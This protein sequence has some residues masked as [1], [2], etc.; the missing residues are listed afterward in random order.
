MKTIFYQTEVFEKWRFP[1]TIDRV[2]KV[3][4]SLPTKDVEGL[5]SVGLVQSDRAT[6]HR[7]GVYYSQPKPVIKL[8]AYP[9]DLRYKQPSEVK[10]KHFEL[11]QRV[12][13]EFGMKILLE[14]S[15]LICAWK[16]AELE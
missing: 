10:R 15:R 13:I 2:R 16:S 11:Y 7:N 4:K 6:S 12:E 14:G 1:T 9:F 5:F 3:V 8:Y